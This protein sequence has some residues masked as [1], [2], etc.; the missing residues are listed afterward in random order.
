MYTYIVSLYMYIYIVSLHM[1]TYIVSLHMYTYIVSLY[2]YFI[3]HELFKESL[4]IVF[5]FVFVEI[6]GLLMTAYVRLIC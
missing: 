6:K 3:L 5:L 4:V 1:Y 2:M